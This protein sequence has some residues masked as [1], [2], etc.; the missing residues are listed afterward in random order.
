MAVLDLAVIVLQQIGAVAVQDA[1]RPRS[2]RRNVPRLQPLP[3]ASTPYDLHVL[4]VEERMEQADGVRA[5][6]DGGDQGVRQPAF[7]FHH[8]FFRNSLPITDWKSR[9]ISG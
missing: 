8:L 9:T 4:V 7:G 3:P 5:A 2:A 6:A 1:R